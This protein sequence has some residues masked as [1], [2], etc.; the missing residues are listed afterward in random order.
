MP[1]AICCKCSAGRARARG[2]CMP[3]RRGCCSAATWPALRCR[4]TW[5]GVGEGASTHPGPTVSAYGRNYAG[6]V[7]TPRRV[8]VATSRPERAGAFE[9]FKVALFNWLKQ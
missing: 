4:A 5:L 6:R 2:A 3:A 7:G 8:D 9:R 1:A